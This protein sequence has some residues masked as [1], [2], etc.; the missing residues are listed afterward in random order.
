M[1][2]GRPRIQVELHDAWHTEGLPGIPRIAS[3]ESQEAH[4]FAFVFFLQASLAGVQAQGLYPKG[5]KKKR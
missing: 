3:Q 1:R 5:L 2:S 4:A